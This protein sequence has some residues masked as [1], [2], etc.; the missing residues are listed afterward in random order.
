MYPKSPKLYPD[1]AGIILKQPGMEC[2]TM[3]LNREWNK[4]FNSKIP[5]FRPDPVNFEKYLINYCDDKLNTN[6]RWAFYAYRLKGNPADN[7]YKKVLNY[8]YIQ[9]LKNIPYKDIFRTLIIN[10]ISNY[11]CQSFSIAPIIITT[12]YFLIPHFITIYLLYKC[13]LCTNIGNSFVYFSY[14]LIALNLAINLL[15]QFYK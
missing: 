10:S 9:T 5:S 15:S 7:N 14:C 12:F 4:Y 11:L 6:P 8:Y 1:L 3:T 13:N 2:C